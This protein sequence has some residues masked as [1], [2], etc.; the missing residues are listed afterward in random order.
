MDRARARARI[1]IG[2][3]NRDP[4]DLG[5]DLRT[6]QL[7]GEG[8]VGVAQPRIH[9]HRHFSA[10]E[11]LDAE[12]DKG[13]RLSTHLVVAIGQHLSTHHVTCGCISRPHRTPTWVGEWGDYR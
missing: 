5:V 13:P 1:L 9:P 8:T 11:W 2:P 6:V 7:S 10:V 12:A 3:M 4:S